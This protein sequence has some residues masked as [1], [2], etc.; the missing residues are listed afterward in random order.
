MSLRNGCRGTVIKSSDIS[1]MVGNFSL[2][3][4]YVR[5]ALN[6]SGLTTINPI[7]LA[8]TPKNA[9][10]TTVYLQST[11]SIE[12]IN[13][14]INIDDD[15]PTRFKPLTGLKVTFTDGAIIISAGLNKDVD[16][17]KGE[18]IE[19]TKTNGVI[20]QTNEGIYSI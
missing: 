5:G 16:G 1:Q 11:N 12:T 19:F 4:N 14:I 17:S 3:R 20:I 6:I 9:V 13:N 10:V 2:I 15:V 8:S 18:W 7:S